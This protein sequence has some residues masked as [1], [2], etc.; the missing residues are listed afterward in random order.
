[1]TCVIPGGFDTRGRGPKAPQQPRSQAASPPKLAITHFT[2]STV[3]LTI[4]TS[5]ASPP[6]RSPATSPPN[7]AHSSLPNPRKRP[8]SL[9]TNAPPHP[10]KHKPS[11]FSTTTSS[12]H[13]LRQTS[14]PPEEA[15]SGERSPSVE[16]DITA[17]TGARSARGVGGRR[18]RKG[19]KK[20]G[21]ESIKSADR[22][23]KLRGAAS[24]TSGLE[25]EEVVEDE[26]DDDEGD[27]GG[28][29]VEDMDGGVKVDE[30]AEKKKLAYVFYLEEVHVL[31]FL[32]CAHGSFQRGAD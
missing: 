32:Q 22:S 17:A 10:K 24:R 25:E 6:Y 29:G 21:A 27:G 16:S 13:P 31:T 2:T 14:F 4:L 7:P 5:M 15:I 19:K 28:G 30:A 3:T 1:M 26:E 20:D 11:S 23:S 9:S 8:L 18:R 12:A